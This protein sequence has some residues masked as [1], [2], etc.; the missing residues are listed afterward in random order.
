MARTIQVRVDGEEREVRISAPS[1]FK[2]AHFLLEL[3]SNI[4]AVDYEI[5]NWTEDVAL[6][7]TQLTEEEL[8]QID[9]SQINFF[10]EQVLEEFNEAGQTPDRK[11]SAREL[12]ELLDGKVELENWT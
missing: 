1:G 9:P 6:A 5:L 12:S 4:R 3:P 10:I 7:S 8:N 11:N 2:Y